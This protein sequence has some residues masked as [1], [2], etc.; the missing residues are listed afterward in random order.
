[1]TIIGEWTITAT[2]SD[3]DLDKI[4][5]AMQDD[6]NGDGVTLWRIDNYLSDL[7]DEAIEKSEEA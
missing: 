7:R 3:T 6:A 2:T 5:K 4:A 1:V